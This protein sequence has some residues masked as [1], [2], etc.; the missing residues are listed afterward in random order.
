MKVIC[1]E[2]NSNE[3]GITNVHCMVIL[4]QI[5]LTNES[6]LA[7]LY[8][9]LLIMSI[10]CIPNQYCPYVVNLIDYMFKKHKSLTIIILINIIT[11]NQRV[12]LLKAHT[13]V[14]VS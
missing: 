11:L 1:L 8:M 7:L 6:I 12:F 5:W 2:N 14:V 4:A 10:L 13:I 3:T 9:N